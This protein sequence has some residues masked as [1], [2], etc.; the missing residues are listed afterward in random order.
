MSDSE[1][2]DA[3]LVDWV[4]QSFWLDL[5]Y[6]EENRDLVENLKDLPD[7]EGLSGDERKAIRNRKPRTSLPIPELPCSSTRGNPREWFKRL[8]Q[9]K[10]VRVSDGLFFD[11]RRLAFAEERL[12]QLGRVVKIEQLRKANLDKIFWRC[13]AAIDSLL[14]FYEDRNVAAEQKKVWATLIALYYTELCASAPP[15]VSY[16]YAQRSADGVKVESVGD[17]L[18]GFVARHVEAV[19]FNHLRKPLEAAKTLDRFLDDFEKPPAGEEK[20]NFQEIKESMGHSDDGLFDFVCR[21]L[22]FPAIRTLCQALGD[23]G[24]H[25]ERRFYLVA[26]IQR[27]EC[28]PESS[29]KELA[30]W[31]R[32]LELEL[33]LAEIDSGVREETGRDNQ[34]PEKPRA[35]QLYEVAQYERWSRGLDGTADSGIPDSGLWVLRWHAAERNP[36]LTRLCATAE[37]LKRRRRYV[38]PEA[39]AAVL[40]EIRGLL[41]RRGAQD[42]VV[43][44]VDPG[45]SAEG[46]ERDRRILWQAGNAI[47]EAL[48]D[49]P[50][51]VRYCCLKDW[52]S[53]LKVLLQEPRF[54]QFRSESEA[55]KLFPEIILPA[56]RECPTGS[57]APEGCVLGGGHS[58]CSSDE[59]CLC[60]VLNMLS[61]SDSDSDSPVLALDYWL[62]VMS[63]Q[64]ER[65]LGYLSERTSR[66]K[67]FR[68]GEPTRPMPKFD[69]ISLRRWNSFSPNLGSRASASVGGGYLVRIW[70]DSEKEKKDSEKEKKGRYLGI[71]V[72]PGYNFLENLFNEGFTIPDID[73]VAITHSHPDHTEN[74]TNLLTILYERDERVG[75]K[76]PHKVLLVMTEGVFERFLSVF[77]ATPEFIN[78]IVVLRGRS[79][80]G[81]EEDREPRGSE[82]SKQDLRI[83]LDGNS[84]CRHS[85]L[86]R[87]DGESVVL[88]ATK[89]WHDDQTAHDSIGL[90]ISC[91]GAVLGIDENKEISVGFVGDTRYE[92]DLYRQ[93]QGCN[94][95]VAH[96]GGAV[97]DTWYQRYHRESREEQKRMEQRC[98]T[99]T[100]L[101]EIMREKDHLYLPGIVRFLCD[102]RRDK[103]SRNSTNTESET[104]PSPL[105]VLSEF[106]EELRGG[107]RV[108][109]AGRLSPAPGA[110]VGSLECDTSAPKGAEAPGLSRALRV[111]PC[112]VGLRIDVS[113][114][115]V[116]CCVC[117]RYVDSSKIKAKSV[118]PGEEA[119][120]YVCTDCRIARGGELT[121][122]LEEWCTT[123]RPVIP[124][125][126][127]KKPEKKQEPT[128]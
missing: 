112:D 109:L 64:Q 68:N 123:G 97:P 47:L 98:S 122:L 124:L 78:D 54:F 63:T 81:L 23:I 4:I 111:I 24:R 126:K 6:D 27:I 49:V 74:L 17:K 82:A 101:F 43:R 20:S 120:A 31:N 33:E 29:G 92:K 22:F 50:D 121:R 58:L 30:Y 32:V 9:L 36:L 108:D 44:L 25:A 15:G 39:V 1:I 55:A 60:C 18:F 125:E 2:T 34:Q 106:G 83:W 104:P 40:E 66:Q 26:A 56:C 70:F 13:C 61:P 62:T 96:L 11:E 46:P 45:S 51:G 95:V 59:Y 16:G 28:L 100:E 102:L 85:L 103:K 38:D 7:D 113:N 8:L 107:L 37:S 41:G 75:Q 76:D 88:R 48:A 69:F 73:V 72:D 79:R 110:A 86:E 57:D 53:P 5:A 119:I 3:Q 35:R 10:A 65:F 14:G 115:R 93:F 89:A 105:V 128:G 80:Q 77:R 84:Q 19:G 94:V 12:K 71:A 21:I 67:S 127:E 99:R 91:G 52:T 87:P 90:T 117:H 114:R 42:D 116:F 118:L